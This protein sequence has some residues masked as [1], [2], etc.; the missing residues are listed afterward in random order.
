MKA[1]TQPIPGRR[2]EQRDVGVLGVAGLEAAVDRR[3]SG[4]SRSSISSSEAVTLPRQGS[5]TS[6]RCQQLAALDPEQVGDRAGP[7]EVDQGR[8]D[9]VLQHRAVLDQVQAEAG[10]LA[11]LADR[12]DPAARSPAP[13]RAGESTASTIESIRSVLQ[14]SGARPLTFWASAISTDQPCCSSVSW[15]IR[16]PVIDSITA[17]TGSPWTS[18]I[19]RASVLSEPTSGGTTSWSRCS[20]RSESRQTSSLLAT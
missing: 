15:T 16:A 4:A 9:A 5:G 7:P 20:P 11:L 6:S 8:V 14:A 13:G 1:R 2:Q 3:R 19:R 12:S 17:Q 10:E 18:S